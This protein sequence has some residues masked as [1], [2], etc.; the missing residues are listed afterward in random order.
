MVEMVVD[1]YKNSDTL[2]SMTNIQH[3]NNL[4]EAEQMGIA[5]FKAGG[6]AAS[7]TDK[8]FSRFIKEYSTPDFRHT[9]KLLQIMNAWNNGW[10]G[11]NLSSEVE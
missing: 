7:A 10:H 4:I 3:T 2:I 8:N 1:I 5:H 11:A 9:G 6:V